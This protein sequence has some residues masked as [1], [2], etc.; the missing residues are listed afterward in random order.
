MN[1]LFKDLT[2]FSHNFTRVLLVLFAISS[3]CGCEPQRDVKIGESAPVFS[4]T[5]IAGEPVSLNQFKGKIVVIYFW[6]N[7][8]C[9]DSLKLVEPFYSANRHKELA[10]L[11]VN[12]GD[13]KEIVTSY[14]KGNGLTFTML[15]DE[16]SI[17]FKQYQ[18]LGFPTILII[19]GNG[20]IRGKILGNIQVNKLEKL[21]QHQFDIQKQAEAS[22]EKNHR[23]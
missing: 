15:T 19:D 2:I 12:V 21:I 23:R 10:I 22:Y 5:D 13:T 17:I 1:P 11:A 16:H 8:C 4:S 9:G 7:S 20:I 3:F 18:A 14:A 6:Q